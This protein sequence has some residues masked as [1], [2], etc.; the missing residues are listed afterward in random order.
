MWLRDALSRPE[1][2]A[3]Q[4]VDRGATLPRMPLRVQARLLERGLIRRPCASFV[5]TDAGLRLLRP[6]RANSWM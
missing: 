2:E 1:L 3:L 4:A 6:R 5:V